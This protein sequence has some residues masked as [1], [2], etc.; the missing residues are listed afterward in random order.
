MSIGS[1]HETRNKSDH[2]CVISSIVA[3]NSAL[4]K[5]LIIIIVVI[6]ALGHNGNYM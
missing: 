6:I 5:L 2:D 4:H 3:S 1:L